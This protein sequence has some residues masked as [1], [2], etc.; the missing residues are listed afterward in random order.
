M[1]FMLFATK[2]VSLVP[3]QGVQKKQRVEM[4]IQS[5]ILG[6]DCDCAV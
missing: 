1:G 3:V 5:R 4:V 2:L 6:S